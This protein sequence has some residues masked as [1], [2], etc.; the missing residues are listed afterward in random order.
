MARR[1]ARQAKPA[2][3]AAAKTRKKA[4]PGKKAKP[5]ARKAAGDVKAGRARK[6]AKPKPPAPTPEPQA[7]P[8]APAE[9]GALEGAPAEAPEVMSAGSRYATAESMAKAQRSISVSEFFAKNRHL[10]GRHPGGRPDG[11]R[12]PRPEPG[13]VVLPG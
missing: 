10:L 5:P 6:A 2:R 12:T 11:E 7:A 9:Q 3:K 8:E 4:P 13:D 1:T